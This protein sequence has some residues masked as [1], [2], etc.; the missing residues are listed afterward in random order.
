M[1]KSQRRH[2]F[3]KRREY[4]ERNGLPFSKQTFQARYQSASPKD[5]LII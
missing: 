4:D 3:K 2:Q 5:T 1:R